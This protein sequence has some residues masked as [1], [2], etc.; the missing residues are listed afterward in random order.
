MN[1]SYECKIQT[2]TPIHIGSGTKYKPSEYHVL[3]VK[4]KGEKVNSIR[5]VNFDKYYMNLDEDKKNKFLDDIITNPNFRLND[6]DSKISNE[7]KRY[8]SIFKTEEKF[9]KEITEHVK[10][11][12]Q[13]YIPGSSLKGAIKTSLI[14]DK[15][16]KKDMG[17]IRDLFRRK[18]IDRRGYN[19]FENKFFSSK[20]RGDAA[21]YN[22]SKFLQI[23]DSNS[24]K[25][26]G[27]VNEIITI[28]GKKSAWDGFEHGHPVSSFLE[29]IP[30]K[31]ILK[32]KI[33]TNFDENIFKNLNLSTKAD[34][35][36][37]NNIKKNI[38]NFSKD[39][40]NYE[41]DFF[42][43]YNDN[44]CSNLLKF[45]EKLEQINKQEEPLIKIG[46]G[47]GLIG[48]TISI[49]IKEYDPNL[50]EKI[51]EKN[52][53]SYPWEYPKSR[54]IVKNSKIPL[55]WVKLIIKN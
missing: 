8:D 54:R 15:I 35:I 30:S 1:K 37:I 21:K 32:S 22:I 29:T 13:L 18:Y 27:H 52:R 41:I 44:Q 49:K 19:D 43:K 10:T 3:P 33:S 42:T 25:K 34:M 31:V 6:F 17:N 4:Y 45:Y 28:K 23:S 40:I 36:D 46:S 20:L 24:L 26:I 11:I 47:T 55:G 7:F 53:R 48:T 16:T 5:R 39:Y 2:L 9:S 50:F 38:Y 12:D 14:Y 51:R